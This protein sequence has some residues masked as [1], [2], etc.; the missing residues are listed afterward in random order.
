ME[1]ERAPGGSCDARYKLVR[2]PL[3]GDGEREVKGISDSV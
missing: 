2:K 1:T 3:G